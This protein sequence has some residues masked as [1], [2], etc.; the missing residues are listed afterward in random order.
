MFVKDSCRGSIFKV[1]LEGRLREMCT[2]LAENLSDCDLYKMRMILLYD[3]ETWLCC[4]PYK[5][6]ILLVSIFRLLLPYL[7]NFRVASESALNFGFLFDRSSF[8]FICG[9][10]SHARVYRTAVTTDSSIIFIYK[11]STGK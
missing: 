7:V 4:F 3:L 10:T 9:S 1:S 8:E 2:A 11:S 5:G 6:H